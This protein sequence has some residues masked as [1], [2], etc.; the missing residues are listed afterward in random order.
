MHTLVL[1]HVFLILILGCNSVDLFPEVF[2]HL[3]VQRMDQCSYWAFAEPHE[4]EW[5]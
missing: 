5:A 3:Y 1:L 2:L 4:W